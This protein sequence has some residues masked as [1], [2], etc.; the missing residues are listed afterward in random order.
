MKGVVV[1]STGSWYSVRTENGEFLDCRMRGKFRMQGLKST[2]PVAV[3]DYVSISVEDDGRGVINTIE[4]RKNYIVRKSV[5]LSKQT[6]ILAANIDQAYLIVTITQP[7]TSNGFI[8]R[9]LVTAE[10]YRIPAVLIFNKKDL[11]G[12]EDTEKLTEWMD[13]YESAGY[14]CRL[15]SA[16]NEDDIASLRQ[17]IKG[18]TTLFCGHS[19]SGKSSLINAIQ[20][21]LNVKVGDI[22]QAHFKGTHTT[23]FAEMFPLE[24]GGNIIDTPGIKELG[25]AEMTRYELSHFFP[26]MREMLN[27]CRFD[28][29]IHMNEPGCKVKDAVE[30]GTIS[31]LRYDSYVNMMTTDL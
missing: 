28:N 10:A 4:E 8:D 19:G 25:L 11:Y 12:E 20:P 1:K 15:V 9:F 22:S 14:R 27:Q 16:F 26:E 6:H 31:S 7:R 21:G 2:N 29:C 5:N 23:T 18:K 17:Q 3:G 30:E 24:E 13:L